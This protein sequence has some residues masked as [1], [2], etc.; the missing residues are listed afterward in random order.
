[1]Q[2]RVL[3]L[4][5]IN[6]DLTWTLPRLPGPGDDCPADGVSWGAGGG[7][8]NAALGFA[9]L[10]A[11]VELVGRVGRDPAAERLLGVAAGAGIGLGGVQRDGAAPTGLCSV[12]VT[13]DGERTFFAYR[14]ANLD[15]DPSALG[16]ELLADVDLLYLSSH[17]LLGGP[18]RAATLRM[19][20]LCSAAGC[21]LVLDLGLPTVRRCP[22][23]VFGLL[24]HVWLLSLNRAELRGLLPDEP[25]PAALRVLA[26]GGAT[27]VALKM[28]A[29]G[30]SLD[31]PGGSLRQRAPT[32]AV[33]D[34]TGCG[35]AFAAGLSWALLSGAQPEQAARL[36][37]ALGSLTAIRPGAGDSLP[38]RAELEQALDPALLAL[39]GPPRVL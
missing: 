16:P 4:G 11:Q 2:R 22:E 25:E 3:V 14:G 33:L 36:G 39:L 5:D 30:C 6:L 26:D 1:M 18:Q 8:L 9:L 29:A 27:W 23:L 32:V 37:N 12:A 35:D 28:G 38:P 34:T 31:G 7:G 15:L 17:A 13:P 24:P 19:V 10:G 20:E 21:P